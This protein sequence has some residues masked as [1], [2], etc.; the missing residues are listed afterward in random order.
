MMTKET[1][2][3]DQVLENI[4]E[5][6]L[7]WN[8]ERDE[9]VDQVQVSDVSHEIIKEMNADI[10]ASQQSNVPEI[11]FD[12]LADEGLVPDDDD[13]KARFETWFL[14]KHS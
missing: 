10:T 6:I 12:I 4:N 2:Q 14:E 1:L 8:E 11:I 9:E 5:F 7:F 13:M 3:A